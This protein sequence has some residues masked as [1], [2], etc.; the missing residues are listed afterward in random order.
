[1]RHKS[2]GKEAGM[3]CWDMRADQVVRVRDYAKKEY[4]GERV[5]LVERWA[6][7]GV[8]GRSGR[9]ESRQ[10]D[11]FE[12]SSAGRRRFKDLHE[13][14]LNSGE[15]LLEWEGLLAEI[16]ELAASTIEAAEIGPAAGEGSPNA[17]A[18][19]L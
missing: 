10:S 8:A 4:W 15:G 3:A 5:L 16:R 6:P 12:L 17:P 19:R 18:R 7:S 9:W 14:F 1:M 11:L 13:S 2:F